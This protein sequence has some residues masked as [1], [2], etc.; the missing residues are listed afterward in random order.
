MRIFQLIRFHNIYILP[1]LPL[2]FCHKCR[3]D[4]AG[5]ILICPIL[6]TITFVF[7]RFTFRNLFSSVLF[8]LYNF[9]YRYAAVSPI[10]TKSSAYN[11]SYNMPSFISFVATSMTMASNSSDKKIPCCTSTFIDSLLSLHLYTG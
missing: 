11:V 6:L 4:L 1:H 5:F 8:P 9:S 2:F 7:T 10:K 3:P